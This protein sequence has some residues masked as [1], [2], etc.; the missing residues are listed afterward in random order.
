MST[1]QALVDLPLIPNSKPSLATRI[2]HTAFSI[3]WVTFWLVVIRMLLRAM[4]GRGEH[5]TAL[6]ISFAFY[7]IALSLVLAHA[8]Y[9]SKNAPNR[10]ATS[11]NRPTRLLIAGATG[12]TGRQ[13]VMQALERGY[14]VT[15]LVRGSSR[16]EIDHPR[17]R[18]AQRD[19]LDYATVNEAMCGQEAV[20]SALGHKR[21]LYPTRIL[22]EGTRNI[23][24]AMEAQG[25]SR[26][27]CQTSMGIGDS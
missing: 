22:S 2:G 25:V 7:A 15:A 24:R 8:A 11:R 13:L 1:Q 19:V 12:G 20:V 16:L 4:L 27:I 18:I 6:L 23:L 14:V 9:R 3:I 26:L 10:D 5:S 21:F 17:L